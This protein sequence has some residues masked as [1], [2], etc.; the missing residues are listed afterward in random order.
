MGWRPEAWM[1]YIV[2]S[3]SEVLEICISERKGDYGACVCAYRTALTSCQWLH[4]F[5]GELG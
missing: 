1:E 2:W 3:A 4:K 5:E